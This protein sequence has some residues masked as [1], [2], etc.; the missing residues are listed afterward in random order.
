MLYITGH[1]SLKGRVMFAC[2]DPGTPEAAMMIRNN[3]KDA[4]ISDLVKK[5]YIVRTRADSDTKQ[6]RED[7]RSGFEAACS[8]GA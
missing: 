7:D 1:P 4:T 6:A 3:L 8:S 2:A 5:G